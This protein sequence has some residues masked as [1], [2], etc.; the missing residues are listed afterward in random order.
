MSDSE[1]ATVRSMTSGNKL[2]AVILKDSSWRRFFG[3]RHLQLN[4][5]GTSLGV[6]TV[7]RKGWYYEHEIQR[8]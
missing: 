1:L 5:E 8:L 6:G 3:L 2:R 4:V 7:V